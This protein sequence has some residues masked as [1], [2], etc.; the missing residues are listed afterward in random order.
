ML[1]ALI[2]QG[3][4]GGVIAVE[5]IDVEGS[6]CAPPSAAFERYVDWYSS[7]HRAHGGDPTIGRRLPLMLREAGLTDIET[8]VAH[9]A[10]MSGDV[11]LIAPLT[12]AAAAESIVANGVATAVDVERLQADLDALSAD[13]DR[14]VS[15]PRVVQTWGRRP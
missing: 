13:Q 6:F 14:F 2:G 8:N 12:L 4:P 9:P 11:T 15:M 5:D 7:A 1:E 10:G 3:R